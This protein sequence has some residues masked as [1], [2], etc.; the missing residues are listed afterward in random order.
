MQLKA[1]GASISGYWPT[2]KQI[3]HKGSQLAEALCVLLVLCSNKNLLSH[4]RV[5][6]AP[7]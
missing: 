4:L 2:I 3:H 5:R 6:D 7:A 1:L